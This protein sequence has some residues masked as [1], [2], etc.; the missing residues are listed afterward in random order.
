MAMVRKQVYIEPEQERFLKR[1]AR[2]LGV[3]EAELIRRG[4]EQVGRQQARPAFDLLAWQA[5]VAFLE[6]RSAQSAHVHPA[7]WSREDAYQ[8]RLGRLSR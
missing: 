6:R 8:E 1:R 4:I 2:E 7:G 5:V 3:T